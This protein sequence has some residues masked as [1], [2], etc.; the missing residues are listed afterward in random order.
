MAS[1]SRW[2]D[3][4]VTAAVILLMGASPLAFGGVHR[5]AFTTLEAIAF[6][7]FA[8]W[9][10]KVWHERPAPLRLRIPGAECRRLGLPALALG[11]L[12]VLQLIPLPARILR[13]IAP[14]TQRLYRSSFP[15]WPAFSTVIS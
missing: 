4:I 2:P 13:V 3:R 15:G 5:A 14:A 8:A 1:G 6:V 7:A 10:A 9:M 11:A 12:F